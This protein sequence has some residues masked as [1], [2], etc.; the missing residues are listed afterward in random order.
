MHTEKTES[1]GLQH[2]S[3][4]PASPDFPFILKT[5]CCI[6]KSQA[7]GYSHPSIIHAALV[8]P[9]DS[10]SIM[11]LA[12]EIFTSSVRLI[13]RESEEKDPFFNLPHVEFV[14]K[15]ASSV[16]QPD[17]VLINVKWLCDIDWGLAGAM[18]RQWEVT[19]LAD[20]WDLRMFCALGF[21]ACAASTCIFCHFTLHV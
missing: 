20:R 7:H 18:E 14:W 1:K 17:R 5:T 12:R 4:P 11:K 6:N 21:G 3:F 13:R 15:C 2:D 16:Y 19:L 8:F 9:F 10:S